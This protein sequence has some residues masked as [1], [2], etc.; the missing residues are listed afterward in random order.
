[1]QTIYKIQQLP[2]K[3]PSGTDLVV[4]KV[5]PFSS[6]AS[7]IFT[8]P[9]TWEAQLCCALLAQYRCVTQPLPAGDLGA[10]EK[11]PFSAVH[12]ID[13]GVCLYIFIYI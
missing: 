2:H 9:I 13:T 3:A 6:D 4:L 7:G 10:F 11:H 8:G 1:M 5:L 12:P